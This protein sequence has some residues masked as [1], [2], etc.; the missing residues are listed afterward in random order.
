M[1]SL[2]CLPVQLL[3]EVAPTPEVV[4][5]VP[6]DVHVVVLEGPPA[7][8]KPC[9]HRLHWAPPRPGRHTATGTQQQ[10]EDKNQTRKHGV[11]DDRP[12]N[13]VLAFITWFR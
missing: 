13:A 6:H 12:S 7:D 10:A 11:T 1:P 3:A 5:A 4:L 9:E 8:Q 2:K